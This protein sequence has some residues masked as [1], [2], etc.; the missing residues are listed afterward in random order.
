MSVNSDEKTPR[1]TGMRLWWGVLQP[2]TPR[3]IVTMLAGILVLFGTFGQALLIHHGLDAFFGTKLHGSQGVVFICA[4]ILLCTLVR[5][6]A[7]YFQITTLTDVGND[8]VTGLQKQAISKM[9][10]ADLRD[11]QAE[12]S[13]GA[14]ARFE[15][16]AR[17][18]RLSVISVLAVASRDLGVAVALGLWMIWTDWHLAL[19]GLTMFVVGVLPLRVIAREISGKLE[20]Q[21]QEATRFG[22]RLGQVLRTAQHVKAS[23]MEHDEAERIG[24]K[25]EQISGN[26]KSLARLRAMTSPIIEITGG[27]ILVALI[28]TSCSNAA[29]GGRSAGLWMTYSGAMISA[30]FALRN[31]A[32]AQMTVLQ[33]HEALAR[34]ITT[35]NRPK[36]VSNHPHAVSMPPLADTVEFRHVSFSYAGRSPMLTDV[37]FVLQAGSKVAVVGRSGTGKSTLFH[38]LLRFYDPEKGQILVDGIDIREIE[39]SSLRR[40][41]AFVSQECSILDDTIAANIAYGCPN[42][43]REQLAAAAKSAALEEFISG[44]PNGY[45][46]F[47]GES[48]VRLSA[49]QRQRLAIARAILKN[50]PI[51]LLDEPTSA[52]DPFTDHAISTF[53]RDFSK[54]RTT[55]VIA[56]RLSTIIDADH[57]LLLDDGKV[58]E[59]GNHKELLRR[60]GEYAAL[61]THYQHGQVISALDH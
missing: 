41:I 14:V 56:H 10:D 48:G 32:N 38:L 61:W 7:G 6:A 57:I 43:T 15:G 55:W 18:L 42:T 25:L 30:I 37:S 59:Y 60:N 17:S 11:L 8:I 26:Q 12:V 54:G 19:F 47:V 58:L 34:L 27:V 23:V 40:H 36:T 16:D 53:L 45:E 9:L 20:L 35:A 3:L 28:F 4:S 49:G 51:L 29:F 31:L 13:S 1:V 21:R 46:T 24:R 50:A 2:Y 5:A 22:A 44:L 52:V 33:A 39:I